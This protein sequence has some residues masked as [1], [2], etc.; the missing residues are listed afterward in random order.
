M[1][2]FPLFRALPKQKQHAYLPLVPSSRIHWKIL[3]TLLTQKEGFPQEVAHMVCY[4]GAIFSA[5]GFGNSVYEI[6]SRFNDSCTPNCNQSPSDLTN[7]MAIHTVR[8]IKAG[9]ELTGYYVDP[10]QPQE[11]RQQVLD[12]YGFT[13]DCTACDLSMPQGKQGE[14][15]RAQ[16]WRSKQDLEFLQ[17]RMGLDG[18]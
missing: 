1:R 7:K 8:D 9:E 15:R 16:M 18:R 6:A 17:E 5:N 11:A 13:C 12:D 10:E 2:T 4:I 3:P 14:R